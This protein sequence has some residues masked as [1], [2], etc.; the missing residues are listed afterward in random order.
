[1][2]KIIFKSF[3]Y[4]DGKPITVKGIKLDSANCYFCCA[5]LKMN[6]TEHKSILRYY[7]KNKNELGT[8][9]TYVCF[10]CIEKLTKM[11]LDH[12]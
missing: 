1:M 9:E 5:K 6:E 2:A 11:G 12:E 3:N 7:D 8:V 4:K 10:N